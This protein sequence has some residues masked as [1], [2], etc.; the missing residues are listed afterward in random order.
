MLE[1]LRHG[2]VQRLLAATTAATAPPLALEVYSSTTRAPSATRGSGRRSS[3][4]RCSPSP[5]WRASPPSELLRTALPAT[6][7]LF[8]ACG[9]LGAV[10]HARGVMRRPGGLDEPLYN[11]VMG[12]PLLAPGSLALVGALG[13]LAAVVPRE[14]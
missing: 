10:L 13:V 11:L 6:A 5:G 9:V 1:N 2:R 3:S 4:P 12:P 14:R 8:G 7:A